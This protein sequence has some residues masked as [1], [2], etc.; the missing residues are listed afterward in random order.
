MNDQEELKMRRDKI[1]KKSRIYLYSGIILL[2]IGVICLY[3]SQL[4]F[5]LIAGG[6]MLRILYYIN[7]F[8]L[9]AI[10]KLA[11]S[12]KNFTA[13]LIPMSLLFCAIDQARALGPGDKAD[14][15]DGL[16]WMQGDPVKI[17]T[18]QETDKKIIIITFFATWDKGSELSLPVLSA[19]QKTFK[20]DNII[21][22]G[23]SKEK[24]DLIKDYLNKNQN[25]ISFSIAKD[26]SG[27]ISD[28]YTGADARI[29]LT[30]IIDKNGKIIWRGHPLE[31]ELIVKKILSG[32]FDLKKQIKIAE[33]HKELQNFLQIEDIIQVVRTADKILEIDPADDIAMRV[34]L[35]VFESNNQ[36]KEALEFIDRL[37]EKNPDASAI[38]LIKL[39]LLERTNS[40]VEEIHKTVKLISEKF[41]N[42]HET[43]H[44][45]VWICVNRLRFGVI[46]LKIALDVSKHALDM[47]IE[48]KEQDS[49]KLAAYLSTQAKLYYLIG[50]IEQAVKNQKE[51]IRL[52][53]GDPSESESS[54]LLQYYQNALNLQKQEK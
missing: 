2:G 34:R 6:I 35:F 22:I 10:D 17:F 1:N 47:L 49:A 8:D 23:V 5:I 14:E 18:E 53:K 33:L 9:K 44:Q 38:Y 54:R 21:L 40:P 7:K 36:L 31:V 15:L 16:V 41:K 26:P 20:K 4:G 11:K 13:F 3:F 25:N 48:E 45:L 12:L 42:D 37:I 32:T 46:P 19:I 30:L 52:Q 29:P 43:L 27:H 50:A 28:R 24:E 51:V 39:D